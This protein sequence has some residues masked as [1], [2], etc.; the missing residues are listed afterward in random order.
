M[1]DFAPLLLQRHGHQ[2]GYL[3]ASLQELARK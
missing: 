2:V 3:L 1:N